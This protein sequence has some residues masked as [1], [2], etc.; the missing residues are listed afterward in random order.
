MAENAMIIFKDQIKIC[1]LKKK[2]L[3]A[4]STGEEINLHGSV[5]TTIINISPLSVCTKEVL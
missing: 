5:K 3:S 1:W 2:R 4:S